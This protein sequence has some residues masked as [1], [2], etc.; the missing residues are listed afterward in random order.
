MLWELEAD[1][2]ALQEARRAR[3]IKQRAALARQNKLA[4]LQK[5]YTDITAAERQLDWQRGRMDNTVGGT[6]KNGIKWKIRERKK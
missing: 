3:K 5:Q 1:R 4:A 2:L 6:N